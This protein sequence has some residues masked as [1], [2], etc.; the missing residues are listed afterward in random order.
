MMATTT[1]TTM[2]GHNNNRESD[3]IMLTTLPCPPPTIPPSPHPEEEAEASPPPPPPTQYPTGLPLALL[4]LAACLSLL[5][6]ELDIQ[7]IATAIPSIT[8]TFRTSADIGWYSS[9]YR[10]ALCSLQFLFG[11]LY[12][13]WQ[14]KGV[15]LGS[16]LVFEMGSAICGAAPSS[17]VFILGRVV[18]GLGASGVF[19]GCWQ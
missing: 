12:R 3:D 10:L 4:F 5:L 18:S 17:A 6:T 16:L 9:S 8:N 14:L 19:A 1:T 13:T 2:S 15:F 11:R 7:I